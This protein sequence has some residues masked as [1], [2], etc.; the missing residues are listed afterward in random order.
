M[1]NQESAGDLC[2]QIDQFY[3]HLYRRCQ[4]G[5]TSLVKN[6]S[7]LLLIGAAYETQWL[8]QYKSIY[9]SIISKEGA[10]FDAEWLITESAYYINNIKMIIHYYQPIFLVV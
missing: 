4:Y 9:R 1:L 3:M 2:L 7:H 6:C 10:L 8:F 5:A